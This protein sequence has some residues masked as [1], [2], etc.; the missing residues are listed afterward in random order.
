VEAAFRRSVIGA[1]AATLIASACL[2]LLESRFRNGR[3]SVVA[4]GC[5]IAACVAAV[6]V[7]AT[8]SAYVAFFVAVHVITLAGANALFIRRYTPQLCSRSRSQ[9][10]LAQRD[11]ADAKATKHAEPGVGADSR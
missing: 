4:V 9:R 7:I 11:V 10:T 6:G 8:L 2:Y 3:A 1:I 5:A